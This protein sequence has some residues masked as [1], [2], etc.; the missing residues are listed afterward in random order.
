MRKYINIPFEEHGRDWKGCDCWGLVVLFY[1]EMGITL[2][3]FIG[4]Y[5][6]TTDRKTIERLT[7]NQKSLWE[8]VKKPQVGDVVLI[9]I[10]GQPVHTGIYIGKDRMLHILRGRESCV[11]SLKDP[12]WRNR[13]EGYYRHYESS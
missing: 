13:I 3:D 6:S 11:E 8:R 10:Y 1:E 4:Q 2:P 7:N 12:E 5:E 9:N